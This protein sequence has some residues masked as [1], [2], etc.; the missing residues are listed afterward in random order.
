[1]GTDGDTALSDSM[2]IGWRRNVS[3]DFGEVS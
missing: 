1:M 3:V 2:L